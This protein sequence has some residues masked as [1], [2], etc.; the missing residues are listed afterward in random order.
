MEKMRYYCW[1][2][3]G[4]FVNVEFLLNFENKTAKVFSK[5]PVS[6]D[7]DSITDVG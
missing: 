6:N 3:K 7:S 4:M 1:T 2:V 5:Y